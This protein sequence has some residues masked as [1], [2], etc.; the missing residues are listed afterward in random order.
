MPLPIKSDKNNTNT[1]N[2]LGEKGIMIPILQTRKLRH[3]WEVGE[4]GKLASAS[5]VR[6]ILLD[7][8]VSSL[9]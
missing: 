3:S 6:M 8:A 2:S 5:V 7:A 4:P 1:N 9:W